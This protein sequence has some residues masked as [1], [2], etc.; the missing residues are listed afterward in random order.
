MLLPP[1]LKCMDGPVVVIYYLLPD[2]ALS[3]HERNGNE[4]LLD[5]S[6][7]GDEP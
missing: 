5:S 6:F 1:T 7:D 4:H 2:R 3:A